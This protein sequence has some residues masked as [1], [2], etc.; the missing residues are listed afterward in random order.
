MPDQ[1]APILILGLLAAYA[2]DSL[3]AA[4]NFSVRP[5]EIDLSNGV[6]RMLSLINNT[7]LPDE[8]QYPGLGSTF[9]MDLDFLKGLQEQWLTEFNWNKEQK[10]MNESVPILFHRDLVRSFAQTALG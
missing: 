6:P 3:V 5:L 4:A 10:T 9:G 2:A 7:Q 1:S 8:P